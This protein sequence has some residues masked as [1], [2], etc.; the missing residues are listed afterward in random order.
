MNGRVG[1]ER[2]RHATAIA[3]AAGVVAADQATKT[4]VTHLLGQA[5]ADRSLNLIGSRLAIEYVENRGVAFGVLGG[6]GP[7][8]TVLAVAV[9]AALLLYYHRVAVKSPWLVG[10]VGLI[11]GGAIGNLIDRLR[12]GYVVDFVAVG[13]WPTF[14]LADSA[15]TVGVGL[16]AVSFLRDEPAA[17]SPGEAG[18]AARPGAGPGV[19]SEVEGSADG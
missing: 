10:A 8:V 1:S 6:L 4:G 16:L 7:A 9:L 19:L 2:S 14:N 5:G 11:A 15:I 3:I 17:P 13:P 12:L 18:R